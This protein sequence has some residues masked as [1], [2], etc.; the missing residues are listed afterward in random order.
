MQVY[1]WLKE[2]SWKYVSN[3]SLKV[4]QTVEL[5]TKMHPYMSKIQG[6]NHHI[7]KTCEELHFAAIF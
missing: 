7:V 5:F 3:L 4:F 2:R 1:L 6:T